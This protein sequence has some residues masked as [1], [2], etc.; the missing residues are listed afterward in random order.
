MPFSSS[1]ARILSI[2]LVP[3]D[4]HHSSPASV[5]AS[6][7][8]SDSEGS[9]WDNYIDFLHPSMF[10]AHLLPPHPS[11]NS[12]SK[13]LL[14]SSGC[15]IREEPSS[16]VTSSLPS[17]PEPDPSTCAIPSADPCKLGRQ[18]CQSLWNLQLFLPWATC[19][20][21]LHLGLGCSCG[22]LCSDSAGSHPSTY[23]CLQVFLLMDYT[24]LC[25]A[26]RLPPKRRAKLGG[27]MLRN[28]HSQEQQEL[29]KNISAWRSPASLLQ[30]VFFLTFFAAKGEMRKES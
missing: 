25:L 9:W 6:H 26:D 1:T 18:S 20:G 12:S 17:T 11:C 14:P 19:Q 27:W 5:L 30:F 8:S 10:L 13:A 7:A 23:F 22:F 3:S 29:P 21:V 16:R 28:G 4:L 2:F 24:M 15:V